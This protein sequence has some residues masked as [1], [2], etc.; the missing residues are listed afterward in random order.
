MYNLILN[1]NWDKQYVYQTNNIETAKGSDLNNFIEKKT[2]INS[3]YFN[4]YYNL[5]KMM[6]G[7][8][9]L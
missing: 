6:L 7:I 5:M 2:H 8:S 9:L 3:K 4:L 1:T